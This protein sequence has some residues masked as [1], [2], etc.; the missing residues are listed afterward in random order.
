MV[1]A[2]YTHIGRDM[3]PLCCA[4]TRFSRA[5]IVGHIPYVLGVAYVYRLYSNEVRLILVER[6]LK[7]NV[8]IRTSHLQGT[9][10]GETLGQGLSGPKYFA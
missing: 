8:Y 9:F 6:R 5:D 1:F 10:L 3:C 7:E 2:E 4:T